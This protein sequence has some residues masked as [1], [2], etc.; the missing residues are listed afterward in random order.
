MLGIQIYRCCGEG[1]G[2]SC[3]L[4]KERDYEWEAINKLGK[5]VRIASYLQIGLVGW[6]HQYRYSNTFYHE[7]NK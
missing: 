7:A 4:G 6:T 1:V 5:N 2:V 3:A